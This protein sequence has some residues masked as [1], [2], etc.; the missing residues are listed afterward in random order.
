MSRADPTLAEGLLTLKLPPRDFSM[1]HR[2]SLILSLFKEQ[3]TL[4]GP[5]SVA[6][7]FDLDGGEFVLFCFVFLS[8]VDIAL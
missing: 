2:K 1:S 4:M 8:L 6:Q 3:T 5:I 7:S